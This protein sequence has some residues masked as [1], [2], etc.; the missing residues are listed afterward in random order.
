MQIR[1]A[2]P[3]TEYDSVNAYIHADL[4]HLNEDPEG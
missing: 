1:Q 2:A 4:L 3:V